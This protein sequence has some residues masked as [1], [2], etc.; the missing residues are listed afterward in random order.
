MNALLSHVPATE[1]KFTIAVTRY[2][3]AN[4]FHTMTDWYNAFYVMKVFNKTPQDV[5]ILL[6]DGHPK[7]QLDV[8]W[9]TLFGQC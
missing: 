6:I 4:L 1:H 7:S 5:K 2:E 9:N 8:T 3:Y